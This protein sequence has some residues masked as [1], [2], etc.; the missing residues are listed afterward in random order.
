MTTKQIEPE[1]DAWRDQERRQQ[2]QAIRRKRSA[3]LLAAFYYV[4]DIRQHRGWC[5]PFIWLGTNAITVYLVDNVVHF[6]RLAGRLTGGSVQQFLDTRVA[7]G[8]GDFVTALVG[9]ALAFLF[10][11]FLYRRGIFLRL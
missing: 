8:L 5:Q 11:R 9:L 1:L 2:R 7:N 10:C 4:V 6:E 3:L